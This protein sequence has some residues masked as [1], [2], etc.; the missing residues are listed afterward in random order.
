MVAELIFGNWVLGEQ[1]PYK[2]D[3]RLFSEQQRHDQHVVNMGVEIK[4]EKC[5]VSPIS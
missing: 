3:V 5:F 1:A 4:G 2:N